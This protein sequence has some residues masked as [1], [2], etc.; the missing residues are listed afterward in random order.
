MQGRAGLRNLI[1]GLVILS[2]WIAGTALAAGTAPPEPSNAQKVDEVQALIE[3][4][5]AAR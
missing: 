2:C 1:P 5:K 3:A 4:A